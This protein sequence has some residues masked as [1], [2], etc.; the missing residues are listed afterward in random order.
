MTPET[1]ACADILCNHLRG[2]VSRARLI[3]PDKFD[4]TFAPPAPTPRILVT[5]AWQWLVC[6]RQHL[7]QPD[8][9][10]HPRVP[11]APTDQQAL[12]D[13]LAAETDRWEQLL[14]SLTDERMAETR[15]QFNDASWDWSV[16][17][18]VYHM[19]QNCIYKHGQLS[20]L[21]FALG[22]DGTEAYTAPFPNP[23]YDEVFGPR[24]SPI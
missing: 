8:A 24:P 5:H 21:F 15:Q 18:S 4:W 7:E 14:A 9:S 12:C 1:K 17:G 22:L 16:R 3:P 11:D 6:D 20:T 13:A 23:I 2:M 19:V 10:L